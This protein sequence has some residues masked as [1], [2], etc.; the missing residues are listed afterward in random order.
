LRRV[1]FVAGAVRALRGVAAAGEASRGQPRVWPFSARACLG[2]E[3]A[4]ELSC[5]ST[6]GCNGCDL[7]AR[8]VLVDD[9]FAVVL[10]DGGVAHR[11]AIAP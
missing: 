6:G 8:I 2:P 3:A 7:D 1:R 11:G 10:R 5:A 9:L 4:G